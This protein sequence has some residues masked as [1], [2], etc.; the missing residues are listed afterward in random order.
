MLDEIN[1]YIEKS[2]LDVCN[3][4]YLMLLLELFCYWIKYLK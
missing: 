1:K 2:E 3:M 4:G